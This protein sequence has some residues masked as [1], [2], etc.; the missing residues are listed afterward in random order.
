MAKSAAF[1]NQLLALIFN[2][3][4]ITNL[5]QNGVSPLTVLYVALHTADPST[6]AGSG[7]LGTQN[8]SEIA[9]TSYARVSVNRTTGAG[10]FTVTTNSV[11]PA[12]TI[13]FPLG[14]GG[15]GTASFWSVGA[16]SSGATEIYY[17]GAV[18][19]TIATGSGVTPILT[20]GSTVSET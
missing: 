17:S 8:A 7:T 1:E 15:S 16:A 20:T 13:S 19:P 12:S 6:T 2:A 4:A 5:A 14:T 18:S 9:Y 10:G 3:T 11:S